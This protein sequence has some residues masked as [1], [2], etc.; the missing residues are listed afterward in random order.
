MEKKSRKKAKLDVLLGQVERKV[1]ATKPA[2][3]TCQAWYCD[4]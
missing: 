4:L 2:F 3:P 1:P